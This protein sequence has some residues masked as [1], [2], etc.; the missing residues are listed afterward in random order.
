MSYSATPR[1]VTH[2]APLSMG[3]SRQEYWSGLSCS[4]SGNLPEPGIEPH[5]LHFLHWQVGSLPLEPPGKSQN[6]LC[7]ITMLVCIWERERERENYSATICP[8]EELQQISLQ[9]YSVTFDTLEIFF[10]VYIQVKTKVKN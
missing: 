10:L 4:P 1:T 2:Q 3:F 5:L 7:T 9:I 8:R 6:T